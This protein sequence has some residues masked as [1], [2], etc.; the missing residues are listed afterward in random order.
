M[1]N[2]LESLS[3]DLSANIENTS[4]S[5][6]AV[7]GRHSSGTGIHWRPG[8]IV[9]SCEAIDTEDN[10]HLTLP[11]GQ[12][13]ETEVLGSDPTTDVAILSLAEGTKLLTVTIGDVQALALGQLVSTVGQS[14]QR[15]WR[16]RG[17][18]GGRNRRGRGRRPSASRPEE[19]SESQSESQSEGQSEGSS[20]E[21]YI[22][23]PVS[24]FSSLGMVSQIGG[25][26]R[27]QSG[28]QLDRYIA[29]NL[30][31]RRGSAGC[32]LI[33]A[34]GEVVG[35]NTFGPRRSVLT[36]PAT[37]I[38]KAIDQLQ[39]RGKISRGYLGL[40]MQMVPLP[41]NV[42]QQHQ[43]TQSAGIMVV[44]VEP[45]SAADEAGMVL[46]DVMIAIDDVPLESLRQ[47]QALLNPQSVGQTLNVSLLRAGQHQTVA[48]TV[49]ER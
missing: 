19:Q 29:V 6:V 47:I 40:G 14:V 36:I 7:Q 32:P 8:L 34:S 33:N 42:K 24:Q 49:G 22:S 38:D 17:G 35:F 5:I 31:L 4:R 41:E 11:N 39:Q 15:N 45:D 48:V 43:L 25:P 46:G 12:T 3:S 1:A 16:G 30:N 18:R 13:V 23:Q 9:T 2:T 21:P 26:W 27:S 37:N 28:G 44:S 10:L 20:S